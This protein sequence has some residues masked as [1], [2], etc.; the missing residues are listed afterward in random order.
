MVEGV[1]RTDVVPTPAYRE[2]AERSRFRGW[3]SADG[4]SDYRAAPGRYH[5]YV[6]YACPF[7]HRT[8]LGRA[9]LGLEEANSISVLDP[10]WGGPTGWV[11]GAPPVATPDHVNGLGSLPEVYRKA[12][13]PF[14][15]KVTVPAL[16]DRDRA[17]IVNNESAEILRMLE[18][19]FGAFADPRVELYPEAL[20][21][22]IDEINAFVGPRV[23]GGVYR[24]GFAATQEAY[25]A[26]VV[27]LFAALDALEEHLSTRDFLVGERLSEAD[28]RLFPTLVRFDVAYYGALRCN[29]KRLPDYPRLHA[30]TRRIYGLPGVAE[31]VRLDHVKRHYWDDHEMINRRIVPIG[32]KVELDEGPVAR[33]A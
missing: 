10:D 9:L 7:A 17:T 15:G 31:T 16:W 2:A 29:L 6:S 25:D 5:L 26:A 3:V 13:P 1:W 32:P 33:A 22:D 19:E 20:R 28:P 23:N 11:F 21:A 14:T 24:A 18:T 12:S 8:L 27:D 30:Y 4:S